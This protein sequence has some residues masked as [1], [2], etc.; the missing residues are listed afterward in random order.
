MGDNPLPLIPFYTY[1][2]SVA[3]YA[4]LYTLIVLLVGLILFEDR[5]LA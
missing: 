4:V 2:A 1:V 5:D 3:G